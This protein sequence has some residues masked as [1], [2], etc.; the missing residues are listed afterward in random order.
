MPLVLS[1][2]KLGLKTCKVLGFVY[3]FILPRLRISRL[4]SDLISFLFNKLFILVMVGL[5]CCVGFL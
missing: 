4:F 3:C 2:T 5:R 1:V